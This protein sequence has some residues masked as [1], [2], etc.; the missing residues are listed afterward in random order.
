MQFK[1]IYHISREIKSV[2]YC[3]EGRG[4]NPRPVLHLLRFTIVDPYLRVDIQ[5]YQEY[6]NN[7]D[8]DLKIHVD[9]C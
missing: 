4:F 5:V 3:T 7:S 1:Y 8:E 6:R 2:T 9:H